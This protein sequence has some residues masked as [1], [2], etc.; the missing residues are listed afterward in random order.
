MCSDDSFANK[1]ESEKWHLL[2]SL[3]EMR[4]RRKDVRYYKRYR[5]VEFQIE[6][7]TTKW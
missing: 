4:R 7:T 2:D 5:I 6:D 1:E 3:Y